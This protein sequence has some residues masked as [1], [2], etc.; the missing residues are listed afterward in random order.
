LAVQ[1]NA[2]T[3]IGR[4]VK[5]AQYASNIFLLR[6]KNQEEL[7]EHGP[8]T[9]SHIM[10]AIA[11]RLQGEQAQGFETDIRVPEA[12]GKFS[13]KPNDLF[14]DVSN[15]KVQEKGDYKTALEKQAGGLSF[16]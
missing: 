15:F 6:K 2:D 10:R 14:F 8:H 4:S 12:N 13:Y 1:T 3:D 5:I 11:T 7:A 16:S 9:G